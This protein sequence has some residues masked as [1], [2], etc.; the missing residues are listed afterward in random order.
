METVANR[1]GTDH[2]IILGDFNF[3]QIDYN[4]EYVSAA[5]DDPS[6]LFFN[7]SRANCPEI[8]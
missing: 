6:I 1:A 3:P 4:N 7:I 8:N 5:D 2:V